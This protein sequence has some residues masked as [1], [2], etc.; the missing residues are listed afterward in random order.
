MKII[1]SLLLILGTLSVSSQN[2]NPV[3]WTFDS[4]K[5]EDGSY[6]LLLKANVDEGWSIYSQ[7]TVD[8][9]PIATSFVFEENTEAEL[10]DKVI[11]PDDK[12]E[13]YDENF[14]VKVIKL[15]GSPEFFQKVKAAAGTTI[16]GTITYMCC[17]DT[18]CLA[19]VDVPFSITLE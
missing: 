19:P 9:G 16:K 17:D 6:K 7:Y 10:I 5:I 14:E 13:K 11:E 4:E 1:A 3:K 12:E 2:L 8:G 18:K 15:K